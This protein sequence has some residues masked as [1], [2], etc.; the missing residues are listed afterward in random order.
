[1]IIREKWLNIIIRQGLRYEADYV[2]TV[3]SRFSLCELI[4][5][6][7]DTQGLYSVRLVCSHTYIR[8]MHTYHERLTCKLFYEATKSC[9]FWQQVLCS[10][11]PYRHNY[12][13]KLSSCTLQ[14]VEHWATQRLNIYE[15]WVTNM[16]LDL[17]LRVFPYLG[18]ARITESELLPGGRWPL[19]SC[20]SS[21]YILYGLH[22][23][24]AQP[25]KLAIR[26]DTTAKIDELSSL[27]IWANDSKEHLSFRFVVWNRPGQLEEEYF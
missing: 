26:G 22:M 3:R 7:L 24:S 4:F 20:H 21:Q 11:G 27:R 17:R 14:E 18:E 12:S 9:Q 5:L 23:Q 8:H 6:H 16:P 1:M 13:K 2:I 15:R 19:T 25:R 10:T